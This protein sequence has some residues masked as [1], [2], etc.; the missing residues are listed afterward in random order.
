MSIELRWAVLRD[1]E[2]AYSVPRFPEMAS[3]Q[4]VTVLQYRVDGGEWTV[5][6][7]DWD[8]TP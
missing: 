4:F 5:V 1:E 6:P 3:G 2:V 7:H 8:T